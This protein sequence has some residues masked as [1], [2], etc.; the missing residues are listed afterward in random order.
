MKGA[1]DGKVVE[2]EGGQK[3]ARKDGSLRNKDN[4]F[5]P[6]NGFINFRAGE[7]GLGGAQAAKVVGLKPSSQ[8]PRPVVIPATYHLF[9]QPFY[10][11]L[12]QLTS[13]NVLSQ[14]MAD[15]G[16]GSDGVDKPQLEE[17][18]AATISAAR[19][20]KVSAEIITKTSIEP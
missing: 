2:E 19:V 11:P 6:E 16:N 10:F 12:Y 14:Q 7:L 20:E 15:S 8:V 13:E 5:L 18:P 4:L 9:W 3:K 17:E 1:A